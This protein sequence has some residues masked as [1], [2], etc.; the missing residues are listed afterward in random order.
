MVTVCGG[1]ATTRSPRPRMEMLAPQCP[2]LRRLSGRAAA[3][4]LSCSLGLRPSP[5]GPCS[6]PGVRFS[7]MRAPA[8]IPPGPVPLMRAFARKTCPVPPTSPVP[9]TTSALPRLSHPGSRRTTLTPLGPPCVVDHDWRGS[10][11]LARSEAIWHVRSLCRQ[12]V[13]VSGAI[14]VTV[15]RL[16]RLSGVL[17]VSVGRWGRYATRRALNDAK[18]PVRLNQSFPTDTCCRTAVF[19]HALDHVRPPSPPLPPPPGG[20]AALFAS[21]AP[22]APRYSPTW[23]ITPTCYYVR[24]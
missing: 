7:S 21:A 22:V 14:V 24:T 10:V 23:Q 18:G 3:L 17:V 11:E 20:A 2:R 8:P 12:T 6:P 9:P 1:A 13:R 19:S 16:G 15:G 4:D 5:P